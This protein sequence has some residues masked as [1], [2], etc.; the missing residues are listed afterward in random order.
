MSLLVFLFKISVP[1][2]MVAAMTLAARRWGPTFGGLIMGLP[3]MTGPVLFFL[4]LDKGEAFALSAAVGVEIGVLSLIAYMF[5]FAIVSTW[6]TW[7]LS[8]AAA[9]VAFMAAALATRSIDVGLVPATAM[10]M[11]GLGASYFLLPK[12]QTATLPAPLPWWDIHARMATT[13]GL[14][15]MIMT[16]ADVL[17]GQLSGVFATFPVIMTVIGSFTLQQSGRD[18]LRRMLRGVTL[19]LLS[20]CMFFLVMGLSLPHVGLV[21]AYGLAVIVAVGMS[22]GMIALAALKR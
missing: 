17:G 19:S 11:A 1:P 18:A 6:A 7:P 5:A 8:L 20:F 2:V 9:V 21:G 4:A 3:W 22:A 10:A 15:A 13:L 16:G 12:P 14:V